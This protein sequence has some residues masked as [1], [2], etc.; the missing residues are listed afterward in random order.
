MEKTQKILDKMLK[1]IAKVKS[2]GS[3]EEVKLARGIIL[4]LIVA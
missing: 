1:R 4:V 2:D 3:I